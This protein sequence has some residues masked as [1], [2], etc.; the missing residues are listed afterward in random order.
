MS[1]YTSISSDKLAGLIGAV[2][3]PT[4][5]DVCIDQDF[6]AGPRLIPGAARRSFGCVW[7]FCVLRDIEV[8]DIKSIAEGD[9]RQGGQGRQETASSSTAAVR[10][11]SKTSNGRYLRLGSEDPT[12]SRRR[13][14]EETKE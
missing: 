14:P 10:S 9:G 12:S 2:K 6:A 13:G 7:R 1:S 8:G 11:K 3:A 5:I 4:L